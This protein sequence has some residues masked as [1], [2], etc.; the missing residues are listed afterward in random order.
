VQALHDWLAT[1][2]TQFEPVFRKLDRWG[3]VEHHHLGANEIGRILSRRTPRRV[4]RQRLTA[5]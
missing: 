3:N 2:D 5:A 1:S 4:R